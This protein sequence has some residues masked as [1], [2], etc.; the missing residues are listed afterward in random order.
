MSYKCNY[1]GKITNDRGPYRKE[2]C[3]HSPSDRHEWRGLSNDFSNDTK[4]SESLVG[5]YWKTFLFLFLLFVLYSWFF[6]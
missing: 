2:Y 1:C 3:S 6:A 5:R 4:W